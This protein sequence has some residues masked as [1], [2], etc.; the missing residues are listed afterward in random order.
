M[1]LFI[2]AVGIL[3]MGCSG[4]SNST[5]PIDILADTNRDGEVSTDDNEGEEAWSATGGAV[6]LPNLDDDNLDGV[7]DADDGVVNTS[8]ESDADLADLAPLV[9]PGW[10]YAPEGTTAVLTLDALS[11]PHVRVFQAQSSGEHL[12]VA[13][14]DGACQTGEEAGCAFFSQTATFTTEELREGVSLWVEGRRLVGTPDAVSDD[15]G[16]ETDWSGLL[17]VSFSIFEDGSTEP[18]T[19]A[20]APDGVDTLQMRVAPW[21]KVSSFSAV[22]VIYA[23][24]SDAKGSAAFVSGIGAA[25]EDA[26]MPESI[27]ACTDCFWTINDWGDQWVGGWMQHGTVSMPA[28]EGVQGMRLAMARSWGRSISDDSL[29]ATWL[30]EH[31]VLPERGVVVA[32]DEPHTGDTFDSFGNCLLIPPYSL[33]GESYPYG[34]ILVGSG[35]LP[36]ILAFYDAQGIQ[37]PA[38][39]LETDWLLV[40]HLEEVL[41]F[42]PSDS[43]RGWKVLVAS[44]SL[45]LSM[46]NAWQ[47]SG[48]G[49]QELFVGQTWSDGSSAAVTIDALL[50]DTDL[51][52]EVMQAEQEIT[53]MI[54]AL[55][56]ALGLTEEDLVPVPVL[57]EELYGELVAYTPSPV[58]GLLLG[59]VIVL[60]EP[61]GP[62][63]NGQ[64]GLKV[65]LEGILGGEGLTL[66]YVDSW[67]GYHRLLGGVRSGVSLEAPPSSDEAW[68]TAP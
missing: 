15:G 16:V 25:A 62:E 31:H 28:A 13:G 66:R 33:G 7:V 6:F 48:H 50:A 55:S 30:S 59:D 1:R 42:I 45:A 46:L 63:I 40:G 49:S 18:M 20:A 10:A 3:W 32:Y 36:E 27:S 58:S 11:V 68:W 26:G 47:S 23:V 56:E 22:D 39:S 65:E 4:S 5:D 14:S 17:T 37:G 64:D 41:Q 19:D 35:V 2:P 57:F 60:P 43:E 24:S 8:A 44:P 53:G 21:L 34:R 38:L 54:E 61:F 67:A 9:I 51:M 52:S 12:L 29:P